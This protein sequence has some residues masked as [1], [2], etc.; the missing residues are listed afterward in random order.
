MKITIIEIEN[1]PS[2]TVSGSEAQ[3]LKN[4]SKEDERKAALFELWLK[5]QYVQHQIDKLLY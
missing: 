4:Y 5:R 1:T 3:K 2:G